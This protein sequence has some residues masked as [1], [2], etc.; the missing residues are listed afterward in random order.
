MARRRWFILICMFAMLLLITAASAESTVTLPENVTVIEAE[1]FRGLTEAA[2]F[3]LPAGVTEI[4][5]GAFRD[6]GLPSAA[7]RY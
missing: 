1:A 5:D 2:Y 4:G 6:S 7:L 3:D